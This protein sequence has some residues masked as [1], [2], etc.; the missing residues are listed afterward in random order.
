MVLMN[1]AKAGK[2]LKTKPAE[3]ELEEEKFDFSFIVVA[4]TS[5]S[6][7]SIHQRIGNISEIKRVEITPLFSKEE[8]ADTHVLESANEKSLDVTNRIAVQ[9]K[10]SE[11][12]KTGQSIRV[13]IERLDNLMNLVGE[14][15]INKIRLNQ[16][17]TGIKSKES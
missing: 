13:N 17:A 1:L 6:V 14:L 9:Q 10:K 7:E 5:E 4:A 11:S 12:V 3:K 15:I 8:A 2:V 16:L